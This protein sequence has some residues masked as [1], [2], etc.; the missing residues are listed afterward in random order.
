M[1]FKFMVFI[2]HL[3]TQCAGACFQFIHMHNYKRWATFYFCS[4]SKL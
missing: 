4:R 2:Q 1:I 3:Q